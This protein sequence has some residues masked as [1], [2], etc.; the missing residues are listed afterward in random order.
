L[1]RVSITCQA[2]SCTDRGTV[3]SPGNRILESMGAAAKPAKAHSIVTRLTIRRMTSPP[4]YR[5][6]E[7]RKMVSIRPGS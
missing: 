4:R 3:A 7:H 5:A 6:A 2:N 1:H